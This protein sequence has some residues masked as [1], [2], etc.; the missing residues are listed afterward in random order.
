MAKTK[1]KPNVSAEAFVT[2]WIKEATLADIAAALDLSIPGVYSR[3]KK[4]RDAGIKLPERKG[5]GRGRVALADRANELNA[6]I[7]KLS[8]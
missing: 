1:G 3:A 4:Y 2:A 7:K 6:L 8:K 5:A